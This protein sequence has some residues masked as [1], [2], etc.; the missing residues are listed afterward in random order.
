[1]P[2][3][4]GIHTWHTRPYTLEPNGKI[5]RFWRTLDKGGGGSCAPAKI[6][7]IIH[8]DNCTW[9]YRSLHMTPQAARQSQVHW[10]A[11][12]T[13]LDLNRRRTWNGSQKGITR[14]S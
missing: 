13:E 12:Q 11:V 3:L 5:E 14:K 1:M 7:M 10:M 4:R 8:L 2:Q 9:K 6:A